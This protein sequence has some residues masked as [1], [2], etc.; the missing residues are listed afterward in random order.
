MSDD[1]KQKVKKSEQQLAKAVSNV[2]RQQILLVEECR[3]L[4]VSV[5]SLYSRK[6]NQEAA[7]S[8][9][10]GE[11]AKKA[12]KKKAKVDSTPAKEKAKEEDYGSW[13]CD[14][15]VVTGEAHPDDAETDA[16]KVRA[17]NTKYNGKTY[18]SCR[19]CK[20]AIKKSKAAKE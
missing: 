16:H 9:P 11:Q 13:A 12:A 15:N 8:A 4:G 3:E 2:V 10:A 1:R 18:T 14:G 17:P 5:E 7:P 20:K 19:A 6:R